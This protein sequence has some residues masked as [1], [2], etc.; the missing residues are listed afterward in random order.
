MTSYKGGPTDDDI[1]EVSDD[2]LKHQAAKPPAVLDEENV[3]S[4]HA[5]EE[6]ADIDEE[7]EKVGRKGDT[8][9][10]PRPLGTNSPPDGD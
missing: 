1:S 5:P 9:E 3:F 10:D 4:G 2:D 7:L 8:D 6:P